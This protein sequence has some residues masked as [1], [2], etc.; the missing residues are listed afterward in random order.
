MSRYP[1]HLHFF[2]LTLNSF[3]STNSRARLVLIGIYPAMHRAVSMFRCNVI[4]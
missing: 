2:T 1:S 4:E 3:G